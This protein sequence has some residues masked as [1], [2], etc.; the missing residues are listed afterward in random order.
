MELKKQ[1]EKLQY[2]ILNTDSFFIV[3]EIKGKINSP[4]HHVIVID[5][6]LN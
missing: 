3:L 5:I 1:L 4:S 2:K 6:S